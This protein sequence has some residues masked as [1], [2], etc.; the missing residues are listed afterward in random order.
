MEGYTQCEVRV[1]Q[2][3]YCYEEVSFLLP[4]N[5]ISEMREFIR[6]KEDGFI[7]VWRISNMARDLGAISLVE[8]CW[9]RFGNESSL[10]YIT[11]ED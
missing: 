5:N 11:S 10:K 6:E 8:T 2:G 1:Q 7:S 3:E 9:E 4:N